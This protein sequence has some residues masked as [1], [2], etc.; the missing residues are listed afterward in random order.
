MV[1]ERFREQMFSH[2]P[3]ARFSI[4]TTTS[5][6]GILSWPRP[7]GGNGCCNG[8]LGPWLMDCRLWSSAICL[9]LARASHILGLTSCN[10]VRSTA[11][12]RS[13][14]A[15]VVCWAITES[16][17]SADSSSELSK[18]TVEAVLASRPAKAPG[19][20][21]RWTLLPGVEVGR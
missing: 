7:P 20:T 3:L 18:P 21:G 5:I 17:P 12:S 9:K 1:S 2:V 4:E 10:E 6:G 19:V 16:P 13:S 15:N 11:C 8:N 14:L